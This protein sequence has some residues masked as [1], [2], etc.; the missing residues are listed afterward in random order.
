MSMDKY[1][2]IFSRQ[3]EAMVL[4]TFN[5]YISRAVLNTETIDYVQSRNATRPIARERKYFMNYK[6]HY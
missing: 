6:S 5:I 4:Y 1:T 3:M 2:S